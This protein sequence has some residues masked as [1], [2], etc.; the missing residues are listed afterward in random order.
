L[1]A[2]SFAFSFD[3]E[4]F[5][6]ETAQNNGKKNTQGKARKSSQKSHLTLSIKSEW[7]FVQT[8]SAKKSR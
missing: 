5:L 1:L 8:V 2:H 7:A 4:A 3:S 6:Y